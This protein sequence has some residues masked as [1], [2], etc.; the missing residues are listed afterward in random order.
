MEIIG[1][2]A[3][4]LAGI[5]IGLIGA[6]GGILTVPILVY[7]FGINPVLA[8]AYSLFL[9]G[10]TS[11][12]GVVPKYLS[13]KVSFKTAVV[14]GV[15][16]L[17]S[18]F[19][20]RKYIL[21]SIPETVFQIGTVSVSK[22]LFLMVL[23]AIL[24]VLAARSMLKKSKST[25]GSQNPNT[26]INPIFVSLLGFLEGSLTGLVGAGG[27]FIIIPILTLLAKI[28][29]KKAIGTSL[30]IVAV[31]SLIGSLGDITSG[32]LELDWKFLVL[33]TSLS[34]VGM[35]VGNALSRKIDGQKLKSGFGWFIF[36]MGI[37]I[38][39]KELFLRT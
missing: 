9:V 18:V 3:I 12:V 23:F 31:K 11:L 14:F 39:I 32:Y 20:T 24:M 26:S 38:L 19:L 34:V 15:P 7:L 21:P 27:G 10:W 13:R 6:G 25:S 36:I 1:Y 33:I 17:I 2:L 30:L 16:S 35:F 37:Y 29:I 8:T 5:S 22:S 4:I 28:E